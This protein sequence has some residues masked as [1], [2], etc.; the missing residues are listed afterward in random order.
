MSLAKRHKKSTY[1]LELTRVKG[2]GDAKAKK[3]IL[4]FK[5]AEALK[6]ADVS[7]LKAV[8]GVSEQTAEE[9]YAVIHEYDR[10]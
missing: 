7:E 1:Q 5:T 6:K 8:A 2:I 9:L 3:L 4:H 10:D